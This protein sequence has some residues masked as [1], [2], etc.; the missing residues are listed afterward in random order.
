MTEEKKVEYLELIY[1]LI[2]VYMIGRNNSI[3]HS[4]ENGF[5]T[6]TVFLTYVL[7]TLAVIQI[8]NFST[9]YIN[10]FGRNSIRDHVFLLTNMYLMYYIGE[11]TRLHWESFRTQ[12]HAAWGLILVNIGLQYL[13]E[14]RHYRAGDPEAGMIKKM[15]AVLFGEAL[16]VFLAIPVNPDRF[17][18]MPFLAVLFGISATWISSDKRKASAIDFS[19]LSE[20]AM[21]FVVFTFGEMVIGI[22]SYFEGEFTANSVY[23]SLM[24]FLIVVSLFLSY[25]V[26]YNRIIDRE[27][28]VSGMG[29]ML[30]HIF[31]IFSMN[32][33]TAAL[34]FMQNEAVSLWPKTLFLLSSFLLFFLC[35]FA[36]MR[37]AKP[38]LGICRRFLLPVL[39]IT[40]V[41]LVLMMLLREQMYVN[42]ALSVLYVYAMFARIYLFGRRADTDIS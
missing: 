22:A 25:E 42:I 3:L 39:I 15:M 9:F 6:G 24:A 20:R 1:D 13:I 16:I 31:L 29:Y 37:Y 26:L 12:Y 8:W 2:F 5:V 7:A 36:L 35:L 17:P 34:E 33:L 32:N 28:S 23:F 4:V 21:L 41:F 18:V 10:L 11:G 38:D 27:M 40:L 14:L 19:H 30:I